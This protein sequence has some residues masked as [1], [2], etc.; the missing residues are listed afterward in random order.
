MEKAEPSEEGEATLADRNTA[1]QVPDIPSAQNLQGP[2]LQLLAIQAAQVALW[3]WD[4]TTNQ[5]YFSPEHRRQVDVGEAELTN[6]WSEWE[7]RLHPQDRER[8]TQGLRLY[9]ANP[10]PCYEAAYRFQHKDTTYRWMLLRA[11]VIRDSQN[12]PCRILG[13]QLDISEQRK[14]EEDQALLAAIVESSEDA[15]ISKSLEG[16]VTSW[17]EGAR[18]LFGYSAEEM[19]GQP[20]TGIIPLERSEE[21]AQILTRLRRGERLEHYETVRRHKD[22]RLVDVFLT[23]SPIRDGSGRVIGA[24]KIARDITERKKAEAATR[25]DHERLR[26]QAAILEGSGANFIKCMFFI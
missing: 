24:S 20:V 25:D 14:A 4:L 7:A 8:V 23:I 11:E 2:P 17:N 1:A 3:E 10:G 19:I 22:G 15:I 9:L 5:I 6:G 18:R 12:R 21:E 16:I 13:Y 26:E